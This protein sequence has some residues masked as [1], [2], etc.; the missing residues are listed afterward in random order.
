[1]IQEAIQKIQMLTEKAKSAQHWHMPGDP[2]HVRRITHPDGTVEKVE[3]E[4]APREFE[5]TT[6]YGIL[7]AA[8]EPFDTANNPV[9]F[10]TPD[11][12]ELVFDQSNCREAMR[13]RLSKSSQYMVMQELR[14]NPLLSVNNI[15]SFLKFQLDGTWEGENSA[16]LEQVSKLESVTTADAST[17]QSRT[18]DTMGRSVQQQIKDEN[19][20]PGE[21]QV[22]HI[23]PWGV[24]DMKVTFPLT[25]RLEPDLQRHQWQLRPTD[26]SWQEF[27]EEA[28]GWLQ[29]TLDA[30]LGDTPCKVVQAELRQESAGALLHS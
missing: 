23:R 5:C 16:L 14:E 24:P 8:G 6:L 17:M 22:F 20:L 13:L 7:D 3:A 21:R 28:L 29:Q 4:P 2:A 12:L 15:R 30:R 27:H 10:Y 18:K 25:C 19:G 11:M 26:A 1:M 9:L